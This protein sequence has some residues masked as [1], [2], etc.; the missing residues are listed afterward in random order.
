MPSKRFAI[1]NG[2]IYYV[3]TY[4]G[5][6][7][8]QDALRQAEIDEIELCHGTPENYKTYG[9]YVPAY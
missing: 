6:Y 2:R 7:A 8:L 3:D 1:L 9:V 5:Y 4:A